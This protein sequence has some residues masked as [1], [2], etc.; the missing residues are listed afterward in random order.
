MRSSIAN[1]KTARDFATDASTGGEIVKRDLLTNSEQLA[2]PLVSR[3]VAQVLSETR[4]RRVTANMLKAL[5]FKESGAKMF[6][7]CT[8]CGSVE[9]EAKH[10]ATVLGM[11]WRECV[12]AATPKIDNPSGAVAKFELEPTAVQASLYFC[13]S[14]IDGNKYRFVIAS[15]FGMWKAPMLEWLVP[16]HVETWTYRFEQFINTDHMQALEAADRLARAFDSMEEVNTLLGFTRFRAGEGCQRFDS[17]G[18]SVEA[19]YR[20][21]VRATGEA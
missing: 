7:E 12:D 20:R 2:F 1:R 14:A 9:K 21:L 15:R 10:A 16:Q 17:Y 19:I 18:A 13:N 4:H 5:A 8:G 3:A 11:H 6:F